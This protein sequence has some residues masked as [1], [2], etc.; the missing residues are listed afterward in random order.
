MFSSPF[1]ISNEDINVG[2]YVKSNEGD[3]DKNELRRIWGLVMM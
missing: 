2:E 1:W 3:I